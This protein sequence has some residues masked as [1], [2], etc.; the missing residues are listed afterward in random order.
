MKKK[1]QIGNLQGIIAVLILVGVL[2]AAGFFIFDEFIDQVDDN[3]NTVTN[4][5]IVVISTGTAVANTN[6]TR[7][8]YNSFAVT[9][10]WNTSDGIPIASGNY[11]FNVSTGQIYNVSSGV[12]LT[13]SGNGNDWNVS[14]TYQDGGL[15]CRGIVTTSAAM[16]T[17][18]EL[19]GLIILIAIIGVI[20]AVIFNVIPG[21]RVSGA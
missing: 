11:T 15:T 6:D 20:L 21:A 16:L 5:T 7:D 3:P 18:P 9:D 8:C 4:E 14:Y 17:I 2:L 13:G 12:S 19:L 1:A 10:V